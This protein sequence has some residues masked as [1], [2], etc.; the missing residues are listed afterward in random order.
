MSITL[1]KITP[2]QHTSAVHWIMDAFPHQ[3]EE[4]R[5]LSPQQAYRVVQHQYDG[6]WVQFLADSGE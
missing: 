3:E 4:A 2:D 6:G 5:W 1:T